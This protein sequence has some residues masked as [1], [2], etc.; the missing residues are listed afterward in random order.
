MIAREEDGELLSIPFGA[1]DSWISDVAEWIL[2]SS[3][4]CL[5]LGYRLVYCTVS[6]VK[7]QFLRVP[8]IL[9]IVQSDSMLF[10]VFIKCWL[11]YVVIIL[12]HSE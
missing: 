4:N 11:P 7:M 10:R 5:N 12:K 8:F 6:I 3:V 1:L 2:G 9:S